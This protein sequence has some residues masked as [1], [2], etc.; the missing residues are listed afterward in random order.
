MEVTTEPATMA[1][2]LRW[3]GDR[4]TRRRVYMAGNSGPRANR[5]A[6]AGLIAARAEVAHVLGFQSHAHFTT[7]PLMVGSGGAGC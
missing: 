1:S 6:L 2:V 5:D 3:V 7:A 4:E